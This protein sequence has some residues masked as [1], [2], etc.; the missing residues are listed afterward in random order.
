MKKASSL[1]FLTLVF[2][3]CGSSSA[4]T[5]EEADVLFHTYR[6]ADFSIEVPNDWVTESAFT[7][8]FPEELRVAF[9]HDES[10]SDFVANVTVI[11]EDN[12]EKLSNHDYV[13]KKLRDHENTLLSY[14][15]LSQDEVTLQ[16]GAGESAS[17]LTTF[18][19]KNDSSALTLEFMQVTLTQ[20]EEAWTATASYLPNEDEFVV[21]RMN[22]MLLTFSLK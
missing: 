5:E 12:T 17:L 8:E 9:K 7:N 13:Q 10:E 1:L 16:I 22:T 21:D 19:G 3:G 20:G 18:Q 15:L 14:Q 6:T 11:K 4:P 2:T